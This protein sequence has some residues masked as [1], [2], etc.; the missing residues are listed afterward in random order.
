MN[1]N[2]NVAEINYLGNN[3]DILCTDNL[4]CQIKRQI[5]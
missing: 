5:S 1:N 3:L 2:N 4:D